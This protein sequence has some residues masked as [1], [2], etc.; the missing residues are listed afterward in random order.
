M[1]KTSGKIISA[2]A[3]GIAGLATFMI[4]YAGCPPG[5]RDLR[6]VRAEENARAY[7]AAHTQSPIHDPPGCTVSRQVRANM[8]DDSEMEDISLDHI[9]NTNYCLRI[10][11]RGETAPRYSQIFE[12]HGTIDGIW[13]YD[14]NND[15]KY[16]II[17][18]P[19][20]ICNGDRSGAL[21]LINKGNYEF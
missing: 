8:D 19:R 6:R 7:A 2:T 1:G 18:G 3:A 21:T 11:K 15:G 17:I 14:E 12:L 9:A 5:F 20:N 10:C 13:I 16:D 4:L